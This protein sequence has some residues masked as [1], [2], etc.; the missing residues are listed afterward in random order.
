MQN[1]RCKKPFLFDFLIEAW[2]VKISIMY[3]KLSYPAFAILGTL[4]QVEHIK[5]NCDKKISL[6]FCWDSNDW[7]E[8]EIVDLV[9]KVHPRLNPWVSSKTS[10]A[11]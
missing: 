2:I 7:K 8:N 4:E 9:R 11:C 5:N 1:D 10:A 6:D 3:T